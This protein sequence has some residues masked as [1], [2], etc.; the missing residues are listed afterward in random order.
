MVLFTADTHVS[1]SN[2]LRY[3]NRPFS[4][5]KEMDET[6]ILNWNAV[7]RK[8]DIVYHLGDFGFGSPEHLNKIATRLNGKIH[9]IKG[10][11]DKSCLQSPLKER[12]ESIQDVLFLKT[13]VGNKKYEIFLS[14]YA[15]LTW[16]KSHF[17]VFH[18][19]GHS[20]GN[21]QGCQ[22]NSMDVGVDCNFYRPISILEVEDI[23]TKKD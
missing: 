2:I 6:L 16:P 15:H 19:F 12:F 10:N 7:V 14:H 4:S 5:A 20:H 23:L 8:E 3:C 17:G 13:M 22:K 11:H 21:L 1:H 9:L 18:L